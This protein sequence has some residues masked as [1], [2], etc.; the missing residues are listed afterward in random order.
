MRLLFL[1]LFLFINL[2]LSAQAIKSVSSGIAGKI[3]DGDLQ[4]D[5]VYFNTGI[6]A[7]KYFE[8]SLSAAVVNNQFKIGARPRLPQMY[9]S[10]FLSDRNKRIWRLGCLFID[11]STTA[12]TLNYKYD[13]C[14]SIKGDTHLEYVTKFIPAFF[15]GK[16]YKC[17]LNDFYS[18]S[19]DA[20]TAFDTVLYKY[21]VLNKD[22]YVALWNLVERF[23]LYGHS[24]L[25]QKTLNQFSDSVK[26]Q[27][28][29]K[30]LNDDFV[31]AKIKEG[32][33]FPDLE[34]QTLQLTKSNLQLPKAKFILLDF[35][36]SRCRPCLDA[37][38]EMKKIYDKYK[39]RG[40]EIVSISTDNINDIAIWQKRVKSYGL[41]WFHYL[42]VNSKQSSSLAIKS[43]PTVFLLDSSG[44]VLKRDLSLDELSVFLAS[45]LSAN[46]GH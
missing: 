45:N 8:E 30:I 20:G 46:A 34:L 12:I 3:T 37:I 16:T 35:W 7:A 33:T 27:Y 40:F 32:A 38:P 18:Y 28:L 1:M 41:N 29:W 4:T 23:S 10:L 15:A 21:T 25:R 2:D 39:S 19:R 17:E 6:I 43:F 5:S 26:K 14:N 31:K 13:E 42:D 36:F 11:N 22:S 44:K 9:R 24:V